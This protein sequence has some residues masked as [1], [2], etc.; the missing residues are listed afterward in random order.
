MKDYSWELTEL[1]EVLIE[2]VN[3]GNG[4]LK[5]RDFLQ[6]LIQKLDK[7]KN[8]ESKRKQPS[9]PFSALRG[10]KNRNCVEKKK[11]EAKPGLSNLLKN[12]LKV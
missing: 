4:Q 3:G 10:L 8:N 5:Y 11:A 7:I 9:T 6:N 12:V 2:K 1:S